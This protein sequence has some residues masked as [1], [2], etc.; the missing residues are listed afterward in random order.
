MLHSSSSP[1]SQRRDFRWQGSPLAGW[2]MNQQANCSASWFQS[3]AGA[4]DRLQH[5]VPSPKAAGGSWSPCVVFGG[6]G[7]KSNSE[8]LV[9]LGYNF[10]FPN[11]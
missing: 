8:L 9:G 1:K 11:K 2:G 3:A 4:Y 5:A 10:N 6:V 7:Q